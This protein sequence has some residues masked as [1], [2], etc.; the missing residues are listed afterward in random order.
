M[1]HTPNHEMGAALNNEE[2]LSKSNLGAL[3]Q[4]GLS[5]QLYPKQKIDP[6]M[7]SFLFFNNMA[8][9]ASQPG[10]TVLGSAAQGF[11]DPVKYLMQ[12]KQDNQAMEIAKAKGVLASGVTDLKTYGVSDL[13]ALQKI[14]PG[15]MPDSLGNVLL[16]DVQAR[17]AQTLLKPKATSTTKNSSSA[18]AKLYDDLEK[19]EVGSPER[20]AIEKEI[21]ALKTK[22]GFAKE[23]FTAEK[24][25]RGEWTKVSIPFEKIEGNHTKLKAALEKQTG[26]GDMTAIFMYM[27]MLDPGSVVRESEFSAAQSTAGIMQQVTILGNQLL[28]GDKLSPEQR[29]E[30]LS[31]AE[32]FYKVTKDYTDQKRINMGFIIENNP[33]LKFSNVFGLQYPPPKFYLNPTIKAQVDGSSITMQELWDEM[34]NAEKREYL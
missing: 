19:T 24:D 34:T 15:I 2:E 5:E 20:E 30:F 17:Q 31:L 25:L 18:I 11:E 14:I 26:V 23:I 12:I 21:E 1:A 13:A 33:S 22:T 8:R 3:Q 9:A 6:A 4:L 32:V 28:K 29:Q 10:A 16:T 27:K 7:A